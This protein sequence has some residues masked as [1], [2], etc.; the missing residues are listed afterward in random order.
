MTVR[1]AGLPDVVLG[2]GETLVFGRAPQLSPGPGWVAMTL[3][4]CPPHVSRQLGELVVAD[5]RVT[6]RWLGSGEAQ[7]SSLFNAPGGARRVGMTRSM[8]ALLDEGENQLV[9]L[10]GR[11]D[12]AGRLTD[13]L[14]TIE[15]EGISAGRPAVS[16]PPAGS[17]ETETEAGPSLVRKSRDWYVALALTE[18]WL[19][20]QDDYPRPPSN[21]E[22][23]E[24]VLHWHRYAWNLHRPQRVDDAIRII[25][26]L[27]FGVRDDPFL[28]PHPG[29]LQNVRGAV[30]RRAAELRLVTQADLA[31]VEREARSRGEDNR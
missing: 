1:G 20:G 10:L 19:V 23:Y 25:S 13:R 11:Q 3:P 28:A 24:R 30:A 31:E 5:T 29:R 2:P 7:L 4:D 8:S 21:R 15:V 17:T 14:L 6:L 18:P 22:I 26:A 16:D 12:A 27:A 9:L